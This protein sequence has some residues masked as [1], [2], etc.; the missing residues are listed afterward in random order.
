MHLVVHEP[1]IAHRHP[2]ALGVKAEPRIPDQPLKQFRAIMPRMV[3]P[4][5]FIAV[6]VGGKDRKIHV[7]PEIARRSLAPEVPPFRKPVWMAGVGDPEDR[8]AHVGIKV[9][10]VERGISAGRCRPKVNAR[11]GIAHDRHVERHRPRPIPG[12]PGKGQRRT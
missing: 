11:H 7:R 10:H 1:E 5:Q 12:R 6:N 4:V 2:S 8:V 9:R 3:K